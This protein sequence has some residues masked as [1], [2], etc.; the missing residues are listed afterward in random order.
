MKLVCKV[1]KLFQYVVM[2]LSVSIIFHYFLHKFIYMISVNNLIN[3][4]K[5]LIFQNVSA[6]FLHVQNLKNSCLKTIITCVEVY[7]NITL[8][9]ISISCSSELL[10]VIQIYNTGTYCSGLFFS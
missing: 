4:N 3:I 1:L 5:C 9:Y 6:F 10:A 8:L 2:K 7:I